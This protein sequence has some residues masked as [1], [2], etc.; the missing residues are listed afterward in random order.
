M[1]CQEL[2]C[3]TALTTW[4]TTVLFTK[5]RMWVGLL[6]SEET[7]KATIQKFDFAYFRQEIK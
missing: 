5:P 1:D 6:R 4:D 7:L 2:G 3:L